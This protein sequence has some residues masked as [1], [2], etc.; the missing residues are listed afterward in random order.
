[1][2]LVTTSTIRYC[3]Q[4]QQYISWILCITHHVSSMKCRTQSF[5]IRCRTEVRIQ[6]IYV[7]CPV[8]MVCFTISGILRQIFDNRRYPDCCKAH[9]LD[10][11]EVA[12]DT[13]PGPTTVSP[14]GS[15][16]RGCRGSI[17]SSKAVCQYLIYG[18]RTPLCCGECERMLDDTG[19]RQQ[20]RD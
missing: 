10:I 13:L 2:W 15:V 16:A 11:V 8:A 19:C 20:Y 12:S 14:I 7:L 1:M 9:L 3:G 4:N 6:S 17:S 18:L 5:E